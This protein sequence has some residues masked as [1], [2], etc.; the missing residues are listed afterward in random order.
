MIRAVAWV[1][2]G[3]ILDTLMPIVERLRKTK[4]ARRRPVQEFIAR[5]DLWYLA[6]DFGRRR[7]T[8]YP[9]LN[10]FG[11]FL[12]EYYN[13]PV[14]DAHTEESGAHR[15]QEEALLFIGKAAAELR[16]FGFSENAIAAM[17]GTFIRPRK[18]GWLPRPDD[19]YIESLRGAVPYS[20]V[21]LYVEFLAFNVKQTRILAID[22]AKKEALKPA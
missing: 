19:S 5:F 6:H 3:Y 17:L 8:K 18:P 20:E 12:Y 9:W 11:Y 2:I 10:L 21:P 16:D 1:W 15:A 4:V 14:A 7:G 22:W 13:R